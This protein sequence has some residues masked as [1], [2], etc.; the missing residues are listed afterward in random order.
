MESMAIRLMDILELITLKHLD[1][2]FNV[3]SRFLFR[4][5]RERKEKI[6]LVLNMAVYADCSLNYKYYV[7]FQST[8]H[9]VS[10]V[11]KLCYLF[12]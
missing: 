8:G 10:L 5:R 6:A 1:Y 3:F 2:F 9:L 12:M 11:Y 4:R 7:D